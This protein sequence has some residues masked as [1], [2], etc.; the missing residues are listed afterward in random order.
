MATPLPPGPRGAALV[1]A[2]RMY[3]GALNE[4]ERNPLVGTGVTELLGGDPERVLVFILNLSSQSLYIGLRQTVNPTNGILL[5]STG[6]SVSFNAVEDGTLPTRQF[7][8]FSPAV[9]MQLYVLTLRRETQVAD[10]SHDLP[11][12]A[13]RSVTTTP[14]AGP[15]GGRPHGSGRR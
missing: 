9:D 12:A 1:L 4:D 3:G 7:F 2:E 15:V 13:P 11:I 10:E 5:S 14:G 6:G 8:V